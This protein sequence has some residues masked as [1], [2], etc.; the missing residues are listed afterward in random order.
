MYKKLGLAHAFAKRRE[1]SIPKGKA[2]PSGVVLWKNLSKIDPK[3]MNVRSPRP[4]RLTSHPPTPTVAA[5]PK[6]WPFGTLAT[7]MCELGTT[8]Q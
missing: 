6:E 8:L 1:G 3:N 4:P 5:S 7:F 2:A